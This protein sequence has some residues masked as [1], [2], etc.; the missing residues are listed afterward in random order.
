MS[1]SVPKGRPTEGDAQLEEIELES[2]PWGNEDAVVSEPDTGAW[3]MV[4][5]EHLLALNQWE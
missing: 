2:S 5:R 1:T 3:I 4:D